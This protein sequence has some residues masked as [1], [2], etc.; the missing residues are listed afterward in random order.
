MKQCLSCV[1]YDKEKDE[2]LQ[3]DYVVEGEEEAEFHICGIYESIPKDI[4]SDKKQ[5]KY[6]I[7]KK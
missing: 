1:F 4:I 6:F 2:F 7:D 5:C 3:P